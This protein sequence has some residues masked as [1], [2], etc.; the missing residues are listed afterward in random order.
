LRDWR[1]GAADW[2]AAGR[3]LLALILL[4]GRCAGADSAS[5]ASGYLR[6]NFT[7]RDGLSSNIINTIAQTKNGMLWIGTPAGLERFDGHSFS[8][9]DS[10][11][12]SALGV[13]PNGDL[14]AATDAGV[15]RFRDD[16]LELWGP[17]A[18]RT[19]HL[20]HDTQD[21]VRCL[22][23]RR[24]GSIWVAND[25]GIYRLSGNAFTMVVPVRLVS[26]LEEGH[27]G[28]LLIV[29]SDGFLEWTGNQLIHHPTLPSILGVPRGDIYHVVDDHRGV[30]WY[31]TS[32]GLKRIE[33]GAAQ[34]IIG[35]DR[36]PKGKMAAYR[37]LEDQSGNL[38]V[39][40]GNSAYWLPQGKEM[41]E[42][43]LKGQGGRALFV[44]RNGDLWIGTNGNGLNRFKKQVVHMYGVKDG[45]PNSL[46]MTVFVSRD[47]TLWVANNCGGISWFDGSRFH[48]IDGFGNTCV[49]SLAQDAGGDLWMGTYDGVF[50]RHGSVFTQYSAKEGLPGKK[51]TAM[52]SARDGSMWIATVSGLSRYKDGRFRKY[53][54]ADGLSSDR[55]QSVFEDRDGSIWAGTV[56]GLDRLKGDR[57]SPISF[58]GPDAFTVVGQDRAE[59]VYVNDRLGL[60]RCENGKLSRVLVPH[61]VTGM[62]I[63]GNEAWFSGAGIFRAYRESLRRPGQSPDDPV[64]YL[65]LSAADGL[66]PALGGTTQPT[67]ARTPDGRLWF[68]QFQ[69]LAMVDPASLQPAPKAAVHIGDI[70]VDRKVRA[71]GRRLSLSAGPHHIEIQFDTIEI[72]SPE[73]TRLQYRLEDVESEWFDAGP[74]HTAIYNNLPPGRHRFHVR[75]SNRDGVWDRAGL[76]YEIVQAPYFYQTRLFQLAEVLAGILLIFGLH[77]FRLRLATATLNARLEERL[78]ERERIS[79][80]LHD[81]LLQG[82][83]GLMLHFQRVLNE[84]PPH[85]PSRETMKNAMAAA[86]EVLVEGRER[87]RDLR[88][89]DAAATELSDLLAAYGQELATESV[90]EFKLTVVSTPE[91]LHPV[92]GDEVY[93]IA[94][95]ALA[96][97]FRHSESTNIEVEITYRREFLSVRVRDNGRG[98]ERHV[99]TD[100]RKGHWGLSGMRERAGAIGAKL[101]FWSSP[102]RGTEIDLTIPAKRAY[103][104]GRKNSLRR[105][106]KEA[107]F[108]TGK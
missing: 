99:L 21:E 101:S 33:N 103:L 40:A 53:T 8:H 29:G 80:E 49:N 104:S 6:T 78:A 60:R 83:Q 105:R 88:G 22:L 23:I 47:G 90:A 36:D 87:V 37:I 61:S 43:I 39:A 92:V 89:E 4:V 42:P 79:R 106:F 77:A 59:E 34:R 19:Y 5:P 15:S 84:I 82:F 55:V 64:D 93:R 12:I 97:A 107:L 48:T 57:F 3:I 58:D 20:G 102:G 65:F 68:S 71:P 2:A 38:L 66:T 7:D 54:T 28:D 32:D 72:A 10:R 75:A 26:R 108:G 44:D 45:L 70:T 9:A 25:E 85:E 13:G 56:R 95:E 81:T 31:A 62:L 76:V 94:R 100:G 46:V 52:I 17:L 18:G 30:R 11:G 14:W 41:M 27:N 24:D 69:G 50:R 86:D 16:Q 91:R 67:V 74:L 1:I 63:I 35:A 96:N 98:I 51:V 73:R